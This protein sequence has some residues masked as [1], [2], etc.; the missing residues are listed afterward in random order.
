[1][2]GSVV[3]AVEEEEFHGGLLSGGMMALLRRRSYDWDYG[4]YIKI[5]GCAQDGESYGFFFP[6]FRGAMLRAMGVQISNGRQQDSQ[7]DGC[8]YF[9]E[10]IDIQKGE[11]YNRY[12]MGS[13][14]WLRPKKKSVWLVCIPEAANKGQR[15]I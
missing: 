15:G 5:C 11:R 12:I 1:M 14:E 9:Q 6:I 4:Q 13:M 3:A 7:W 10:E 8:I 2:I